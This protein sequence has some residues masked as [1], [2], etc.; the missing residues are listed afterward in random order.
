[1][2][3]DQNK[4]A[5]ELL[6]KQVFYRLAKESVGHNAASNPNIDFM[7]NCKKEGVFIFPI[8]SKIRNNMLKLNNYP[9]DEGTCRAFAK[10]ITS[11][12]TEESQIETLVLHNTNTSD[13][14]FAAILG[15]LVEN[16]RIIK[17]H[18]SGNDFGP[19]SNRALLR[20]L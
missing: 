2:R 10:Y 3:R 1:M 13:E 11:Q 20:L 4:H 19:H 6:N 12:R 18:Y 15:G 9:L 17:L 5:A 7:Q 14:G 8:F 16:S